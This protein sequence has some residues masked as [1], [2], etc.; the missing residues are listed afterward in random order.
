MMEKINTVELTGDP[1]QLGKVYGKAI[2]TTFLDV[3]KRWEDR[4]KN[5]FQI[6]LSAYVQ[7][8]FKETSFLATCEKHVPDL[9]E[10][11]RGIAQGAGIDFELAFTWQLIDEHSF[12]IPNY[13]GEGCS[14]LGFVREP[15]KLTFVA[16]N[17]DMP[18]IK[19]GAQT[20][21]QITGQGNEPDMLVAAQAGAVASMGLNQYGVGVCVNYLSQLKPSA[22]GLPVS[23][24]VRSILRQKNLKD[25]ITFVRQVPHATGQNYVIGSPEGVAS[26]ECS[27]K[28]VAEYR[29]DPQ[30]RWV[31]HANHPIINAD[32][33]EFNTDIFTNTTYARQ[34]F[35]ESRVASLPENGDVKSIQSILQ[36]KPL[37]LINRQGNYTGFCAILELSEKPVMHI[38]P[39]PPDRTSF[40]TFRI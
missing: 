13:K 15:G 11:V 40:Q 31:A 20:L 32:M 10:E 28:S 18:F 21:L 33:V 16:Q 27:E 38:A 19:D 36:S 9:V 8:L 6:E 25:A 7:Y 2:R 14:A 34:D 1:F 12:C 24:V 37:C 35:L 26:L 3:L 23:F 30:G 5:V 39:G 4:L 17:L 22:Q 29:P